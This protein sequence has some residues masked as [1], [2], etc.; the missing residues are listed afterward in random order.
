MHRYDVARARG[1]EMLVCDGIFA[2]VRPFR[3]DS[4]VESLGHVCDFAGGR[5]RGLITAVVVSLRG[6]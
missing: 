6:D 4:V 3:G 1:T 2:S 5:V